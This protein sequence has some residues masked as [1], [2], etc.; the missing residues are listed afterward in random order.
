MKK[1]K[2]T[3]DK[4]AIFIESKHDEITKGF[5]NENVHVMNEQGLNRQANENCQL[6]KKEPPD[7]QERKHQK[8]IPASALAISNHVDTKTCCKVPCSSN[9]KNTRSPTRKACWNKAKHTLWSILFRRGLTTPKIAMPSWVAP[10]RNC[11]VLGDHHHRKQRCNT[12]QGVLGLF[13]GRERE[14]THTQGT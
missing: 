4:L 12:Q 1:R 6:S 8:S 7:L 10:P 14:P 2:Q 5:V 9:V 3:K 13:R 11:L